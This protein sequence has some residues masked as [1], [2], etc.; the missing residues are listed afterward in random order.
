MPHT[1]RPQEANSSTA[2]GST[3]ANYASLLWLGTVAD[4]AGRDKLGRDE[5]AI[6]WTMRRVSSRESCG[7]RA[8]GDN[9][10]YIRRGRGL[11][12]AKLAECQYV[13]GALGD[14]PPRVAYERLAG[15]VRMLG[16]DVQAMALHNAYA[17]D[18]PAPDTLT[19]RRERIAGINRLSIDTIE[20]YERNMI[21]EL[22][23]RL[24]H[25]EL[26]VGS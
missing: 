25:G 17:I 11:T 12:F 14:L 13:M 24:V 6:T 15:T 4:P 3:S 8:G 2:R 23:L 21:D 9:L 5:L 18:M 1:R 16:E 26:P 19:R 20:L 22:A 10:K 7:V